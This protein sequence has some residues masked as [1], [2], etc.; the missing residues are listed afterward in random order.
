[1][2]RCFRACNVTPGNIWF[3]LGNNGN[4]SN[5]NNRIELLE[6][7]DWLG[8]ENMVMD[9]G[10]FGENCPS[11]FGRKIRNTSLLAF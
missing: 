4:L 5:A 7:Y 10:W 6:A 11:I 3:P 2:R 1:M 8:I 9:A